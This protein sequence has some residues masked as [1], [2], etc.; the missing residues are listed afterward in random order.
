[1]LE[2]G[3]YFLMRSCIR[4]CDGD[5]GLLFVK[6]INGM[7]PVRRTP[8]KGISETVCV[9]ERVA[10]RLALLLLIGLMFDRVVRFFKNVY[11]YGKT[12]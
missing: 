3:C 4:V 7:S 12:G 6:A 2:L 5:C 8:C 9:D 11:F 1:M 10:F